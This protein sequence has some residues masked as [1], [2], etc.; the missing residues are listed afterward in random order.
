ME[1]PAQLSFDVIVRTNT[2]DETDITTFYNKLSSLIR[3]ILKNNNLIIDGYVN[4][5]F[6]KNENK[7]C[8]RNSPKR[9]DEYLVVFFFSLSRE[10]AC[11]LEQKSSKKGRNNYELTLTQITPKYSKVIYL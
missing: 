4:V 3:H 8:L 11:M 6:G 1:T 5:N 10:Q 7:F 2:Y 9:N